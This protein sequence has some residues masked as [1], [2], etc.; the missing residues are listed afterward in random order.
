MIKT[1]A[2]LF[3]PL[4]ALSTAHGQPA[5]LKDVSIEQRLGQSLPL[6]APLR[7]ES[8]RSRPLSGYLRPGRPALVTF[9]Y[10]KCPG[11]CTAT[12]NQLTRTLTALPE[13]AGDTFDV[14]TISF[15]PREGPDLAADKKETYLRAYRRPT[16][17]AGWHFLTADAESIQRLTR[18]A[19][20]RYTWDEDHQVFAHASSVIVLTSRGKISRYFLGVEY[21]PQEVRDALA[22]AS[23]DDVGPVAERVF[24]YC[25]HYDPATGRYGLI[26][27][28]A[29]RA[30]GLITL[31]SLAGLITF[32]VRRERRA[33]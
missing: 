18:A 28:R 26:I 10:Y 30:G 3:V 23:R 13:S 20:F 12:L 22:A 6:D 15:D 31:F 17:V 16:A 4:L 2:F 5:I 19:G 1:L 33:A 32:Y 11:L 14:L 9:V 21:P 8:G 7:D 27:S 24:L 25:F 29:I